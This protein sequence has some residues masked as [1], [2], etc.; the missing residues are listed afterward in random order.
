MFQRKTYDHAINV[1]TIDNIFS[2]GLCIFYWAIIMKLLF[3]FVCVFIYFLEPTQKQTPLI[4]I[5]W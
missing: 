3:I 2:I 4:N 5:Y 1:V